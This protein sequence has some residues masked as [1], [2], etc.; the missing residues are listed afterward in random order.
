MTKVL[1][2]T[3]SSGWWRWVLGVNR[4]IQQHVM[5]IQQLPGPTWWPQ[6][7]SSYLNFDKSHLNKQFH[8]SVELATF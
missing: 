2:S 7:T 5:A 3:H 8:S 6:A 4:T 1:L